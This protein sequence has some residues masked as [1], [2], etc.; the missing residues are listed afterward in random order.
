[1]PKRKLNHVTQR[2]DGRWMARKTFGYT[3]DGKPN[4]KTFYGDTSAEAA[5]KMKEYEKQLEDGLNVDAANINF[6][7]WLDVWLHEYKLHNV[8]E[9]TYDSYEGYI[10]SRIKPALGR[11]RL[12]E[13]R[14]EHIQ[15]FINSLK[16]VQLKNSKDKSGLSSASI[17]K[18]KNI[19]S[20]ALSQAVKNGLIT[21]NFAD[22]I[23]VPKDAKKKKRVNAFNQDE[24]AALLNELREHRMYYAL[25]VMA[26]GTGLRIG[27]LLALRWECVDTELQ[28]I[29]VMEAVKRTKDRNADGSLAEKNG[30]KSSL[31]VGDVKTDSGYRTVP[32]TGEVLQVL[33]EHKTGQAGEH[34]LA[35]AAW[36]DNDLVFCT[37]LGGYLEPRNARR[38]FEKSRDAIGIPKYSFHSLRHSFATNAI[39]AG[40]DYYYLSRIMGHATISVTLDT[41]ADFMPDKSRSE[42]KKMEGILLARAV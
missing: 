37:G 26:L 38:I 8:G 24:Q 14:P 5:E 13:L 35:G 17:T 31:K 36:K 41:Y 22:A 12:R 21:R 2:A 7:S 3:P 28:E 27:E 42:M 6:G 18:I 11:H 20:G 30:A 9:Q 34:L 16:S 10:Q 29:K 40:M 25:I 39:S 32:L 4:R 19:I 15:S 23:T 33:R 1:M